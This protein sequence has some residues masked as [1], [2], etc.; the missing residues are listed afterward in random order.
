MALLLSQNGPRSNFRASNFSKFPGG[1]CPQTPSLRESGYARL[2]FVCLT[3]L[4]KILATG[5]PSIP[6]ESFPRRAL[7]NVS[8]RFPVARPMYAKLRPFIFFPIQTSIEQKYKGILLVLHRFD[9]NICVKIIQWGKLWY[10]FHS[11]K[12]AVSK[13][14]SSGIATYILSE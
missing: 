13:R 2:N 3:P 14:R 12:R 9:T 10:D 11:G 6:E 5:L 1:A 4:R 7:M 8:Y